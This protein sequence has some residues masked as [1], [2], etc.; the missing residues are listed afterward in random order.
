MRQ[1]QQRLYR[2]RKID[3]DIL[4]LD[5]ERLHLCFCQRHRL[6]ARSDKPRDAFSYSAPHTMCRHSSPYSRE[7]IP[8]TVSSERSFWLRSSFQ[9]LPAWERAPPESSPRDACS[10]SSFPESAFTLF[11][12]PRKVCATYH[13]ASAIRISSLYIVKKLMPYCAT[14]SMSAIIAPMMI[15]TI[16]TATDCFKQG[17]LIRPDDFLKLGF[18]TVK[19]LNLRCLG[20]FRRLS[21]FDIR[22]PL[23]KATRCRRLSFR[24]KGR[25]LFRLFVRCV[26]LAESA[27]LLCFHSVRMRF[28]VLGRV[29]VALFAFCTCQCD[30]CTHFSTSVRALNCRAL[31]QVPVIPTA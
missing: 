18:D 20:R 21:S 1:P 28:L 9:L 29:I 6:T 2:L 5:A 17:I 15:E 8:E 4:F 10:L 11:S 13:F 31:P 23:S 16:T 14:T 19:K 24:T 12:Y 25:L 26:L 3:A 22:K 27:V 7:H 30:S